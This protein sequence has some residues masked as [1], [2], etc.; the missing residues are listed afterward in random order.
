MKPT[1]KSRFIADNNVKADRH[2]QILG[3]FPKSRKGR[4][5]KMFPGSR[6]HIWREI[7]PYAAVLPGADD[8]LYRA[9]WVQERNM[10]DREQSLWIFSAK[11]CEPAIIGLRIGSCE[12]WVG[13]R[14]FPAD[15]D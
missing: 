8:L 4:I 14:T 11:V 15:A 2:L 3:C 10:R 13:D 7:D 6:R 12:V 1:T 9:F 5:I